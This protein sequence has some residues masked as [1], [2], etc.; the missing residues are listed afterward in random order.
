MTRLRTL[1]I[2]LV[3]LSTVALAAPELAVQAP[4]DAASTR[5]A[6]IGDTGTG[7][8]YEEQVAQVLTKSRDAFPFTFVITTIRCIRQADVMAPRS[9]CASS[10]NRCC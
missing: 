2:S 8:K 1:L 5:F 6:V 3:M 10:S 4:V 7:D 9:I